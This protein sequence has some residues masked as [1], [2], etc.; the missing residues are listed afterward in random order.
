MS[1]AVNMQITV[2]MFPAATVWPKMAQ[3]SKTLQFSQCFVQNKGLF[4][5]FCLHSTSNLMVDYLYHQNPIFSECISSRLNIPTTW[6]TWITCTTCPT[7]Q[8]LV[9]PSTVQYSLV[10]AQH[11]PVLPI[12][13]VNID[14]KV[15]IFESFLVIFFIHHL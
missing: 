1:K 12:I 13:F 7:Q 15:I 9:Q 6:I 5:Q 11:I 3:S 2:E 4:L 10:A 8:S 14:Y